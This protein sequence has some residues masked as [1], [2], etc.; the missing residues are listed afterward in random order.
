[1]EL[2]ACKLPFRPDEAEVERRSH[3][4]VQGEVGETASK[5]DVLGRAFDV[6]V[7]PVDAELP[8]SRRRVCSSIS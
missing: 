6:C 2:L 3:V 8:Y 4:P 5:H 7:A 1:M